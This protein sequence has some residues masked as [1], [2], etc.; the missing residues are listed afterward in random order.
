ME[1]EAVMEPERLIAGIAAFCASACVAIAPNP[2]TA[3]TRYP[4][5]IQLRLFDKIFMARSYVF[6][7]L[8]SRYFVIATKFSTFTTF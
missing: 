2:H 6:T 3:G 1:V 5:M 7:V 8:Q 4:Q